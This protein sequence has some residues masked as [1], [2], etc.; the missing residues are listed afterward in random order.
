MAGI[1]VL[2]RRRLSDEAEKPFWISFSD[3]MTALM[4]LFLVA[5]AVALIAITTEIS[6]ADKRKVR[7]DEE[8]E[9]LLQ[10]LRKSIEN[11]IPGVSLYGRTIDFG[12][13]ARFYTNKHKLT[14]EQAQLL[15]SVTAKILALSSNPHWGKWSKRVVVEGFADQRGTYLDNLNLSLQ[16]SQRV[17][18]VI[19]AGPQSAENAL[20]E[21]DRKIIREIFLVGG[22]S[23]N[24]LKKEL[25]ESRRIEMKLEFLEIGEV[26]PVARE[27]A[28]DADV[29]CPID[30]IDK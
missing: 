4:V 8:I 26:R 17:L 12:S 14:A 24:A 22:S 2:S 9:S 1:R 21:K 25:E 28:L 11:E 6:E 18:C 3:L 29:R 16:R 27:V 20:S 5:M 13:R 30:K 19:L 7:R 10:G 15:R 23:F